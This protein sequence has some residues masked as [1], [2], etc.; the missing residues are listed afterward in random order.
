MAVVVGFGVKR[1]KGRG[2]GNTQLGE[3]GAV[4]AV[5]PLFL[6]RPN[7]RAG[8]GQRRASASCCF[9]ATAL[10]LLLNFSCCPRSWLRLRSF[11]AFISA[12]SDSPWRWAVWAV[13]VIKIKRL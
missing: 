10:L 8:A 3:G 6:P 1:I 7:P 5:H 13:K 12:A 2:L 9:L 11:Q 4:G